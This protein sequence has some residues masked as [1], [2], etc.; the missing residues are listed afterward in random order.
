MRPKH[1]RHHPNRPIPESRR[2]GAAARGFP[3]AGGTRMSH[4][5]RLHADDLRDYAPSPRRE[6]L[7]FPGVDDDA[8]LHEEPWRGLSAWHPRSDELTGRAIARAE[9]ALEQMERQLHNLRMLLGDQDEAADEP[10]AA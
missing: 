9:S 1:R 2:C 7:P 4:R 3:R 10:R 6:V 5:L 8:L